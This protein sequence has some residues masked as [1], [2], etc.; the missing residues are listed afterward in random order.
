MK[1]GCAEQLERTVREQ[2]KHHKKDRYLDN[3][4]LMP[5]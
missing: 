4:A 1:A 2:I 5:G 3:A